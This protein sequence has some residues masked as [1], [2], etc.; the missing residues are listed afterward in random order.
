MEGRR[1]YSFRPCDRVRF[2]GLDSNQM[3]ARQ[4]TWF[5]RELAQSREPWK[6]VF[7]HHPLYSSGLKHGSSLALRSALEPL[8]VKYGVTLAISGHDHFYERIK[9]QQGVHYFVAGGAAQVRVGNAR[10]DDMTAKAFDQDQS[11]LLIEIGDEGLR[12]QAISR[13]GETVDEGRNELPA[14]GY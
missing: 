3:D 5:E 13:T 10:L 2:F 12:F 11:F 4:L 14:K 7:F 1:Y 8:L 6:V 9:P